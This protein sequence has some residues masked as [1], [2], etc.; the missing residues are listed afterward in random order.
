MSAP[1]LQADRS[2]QGRPALAALAAGA[3]DALIVALWFA[4]AG[5]VGAWVWSQVTTLPKVAKAGGNATLTPDEL[6]K[7]VGVD[8][9][10]FVIAMVGGLLSGIVLLAWRRRDPLLMVVAVV[11]GGALASWLMTRVGLALGPEK[12]LVALRGKP[13]GDVVSTQLRLHATGVVWIW[14]MGAALG[15]L[16]YIWVLG[17]P[18]PDRG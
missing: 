9:W 7:Q 17:K 6:V 16:A 13:N 5:T 2:S 4:V 18:E 8:G 3:L 15:A 1:L 12:E 14:S 10:F 11:L